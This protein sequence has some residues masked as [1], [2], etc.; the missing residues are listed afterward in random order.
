MIMLEINDLHTYYGL[1]H[2]V[3]GIDLRVAPGETI[4]IF[5]R[6]GVGKTTLLKTIAG[7]LQPTSGQIR[8]NGQRIDRQAPDRICRAGIGFIP[9]DRRIFP[10]LTVEENLTLGFLQV[11]HRSSA[12]NAA[13]LTAVYGHF[14]RLHERRRQLGTTLSGGE[15]QMLAIARIMVGEPKLILVDEPSEGLAPMIVAEIYAILAEMK[16]AGRAILLVEQNV[17][18]A[19]H[20]CDRFI[21]IER[22]RVVVEGEA[23]NAADHERLFAAVAV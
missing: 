12:A 16:R 10:G 19:L 8:M 18:Q 22:G 21:A 3:Q 11:P 4:G 20:V 5:G 15:Q 14:P 1:S 13:A 7:W 9:E 23:G 2:V 17:A 6:N